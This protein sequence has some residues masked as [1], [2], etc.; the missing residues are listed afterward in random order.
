[1]AK[2]KSGNGLD[3]P[4]HDRDA[5]ILKAILGWHAVRL[6]E[7]DSQRI[8]LASLSSLRMDLSVQWPLTL[9]IQE[10]HL[11]Q[12]NAIFTVLLQVTSALLPAPLHP[13]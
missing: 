6:S 2:G 11:Q 8:D 4:R 1:M 3:M 10:A 13:S 9:I 12:Y 5:S 7:A